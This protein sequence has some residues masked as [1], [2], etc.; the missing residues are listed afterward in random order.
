MGEVTVSLKLPDGVEAVC[1]LIICE[2]SNGQIFT[3]WPSK[4]P[5]N[6]VIRMLAASIPIAL[7]NEARKTAETDS[8]IKTPGLI[9]MPGGRA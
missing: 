5:T 8:I 2:A 7:D 3:A 4:T 6:N 9:L 1:A